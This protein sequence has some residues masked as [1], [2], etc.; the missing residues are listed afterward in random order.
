METMIERD[1]VLKQALKDQQEVFNFLAERVATTGRA[2][3]K[4]EVRAAL[5]KREAEG[6]TGMMDGFAIPHA[7]SEAITQACIVITSLV[8]PVE[9][10]AMD[11]KPIDFVVALFIPEEEQGTTHLKVLSQVARMLMKEEV[12]KQLKQA[13][14]AGQVEEVL[15]QHIN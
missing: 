13:T 7:K 11:G 6:T 5:E 15:N 2:T 4:A 1:I 14:T 10:D 3:D 8:E 9:W 12:K